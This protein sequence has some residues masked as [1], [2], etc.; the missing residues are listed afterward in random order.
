MSGAMP[1][2]G[3]RVIDFSHSWAAPHCARILA[4]FGAEVIKVEYPQRLCLLRGGRKE[5]KA[6][7]RHPAW[8]Q[9]NRNKLSVTLDLAC[10]KDQRIFV[11]LV[12]ISDV[13]IENSRPG[14]MERLGFG[15]HDLVKIK[16]DL[17]VLSM[18]AFG[19]S[20]PYA[21]YTG[22]GA[23]FETVG[24]I[25][26]LTAY[27]KDSKP[28]RI[29]EMDVT[30]G[31]AGAGAIMT[32]LLHHQLT[33]EGQHI[34]LSQ[35]EASTHASIGEHLLGFV[36]TG[37]QTPPKGNRSMIYA[38]QGCYRCKGE[39]K[40]VAITVRSEEEWRQFCEVSGHAEWV[41]DPRFVSRKDRCEN[42]DL[43]D[44]LIEKFTIKHSHYEVMSMLQN[45]NIP[46]GSVLDVFEIADNSHLK[47]RNYFASEVNGTEKLFMGLPFKLSMT[48]G[49]VRHAGPDLGQHN[50]LVVSKILKKTKENIPVVNEDLIQTAF[51][52]K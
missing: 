12:E 40:W 39:D 34:D 31:M 11:D 4:D 18:P 21:S 49:K 16:N 27:D 38:P 17:I 1:L 43:L 28:M 50:E 36:M 2:E 35:L 48:F 52:T 45:R 29:K 47:E 14:V 6:Y 5:D 33:G 3:I 10:E 26:S 24:G 25:Q 19:S 32:A 44:Q 42:H 37:T 23:V 51:D 15:Y 41:S 46:A 13:V 20:G 9:V 30:N 8:H 7:N 22:Y